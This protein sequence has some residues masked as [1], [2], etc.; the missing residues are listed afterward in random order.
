LGAPQLEGVAQE[1]VGAIFKIMAA[2]ASGRNFY[3]RQFKSQLSP[4][5]QV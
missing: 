5:D 4:V 2:A 3:Q 1:V